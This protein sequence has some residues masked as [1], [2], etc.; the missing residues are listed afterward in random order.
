ME[1]WWVWR[2]ENRTILIRGGLQP[3]RRDAR[4]MPLWDVVRISGLLVNYGTPPEAPEVAMV[5]S[6][7]YSLVPFRYMGWIASACI[8]FAWR[9][10]QDGLMIGI[11]DLLENSRK[12]TVSKLLR[13]TSSPK[14]HANYGE[15]RTTLSNIH[16]RRRRD[17]VL[18]PKLLEIFNP[19]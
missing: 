6:F 10:C 15:E 2:G 4:V 13:N 11:Q 14:K 7:M 3:L 9:D 12:K 1:D 19:S 8:W 18:E 17:S 16:T 5:S